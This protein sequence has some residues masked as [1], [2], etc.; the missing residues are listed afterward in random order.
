MNSQ[1]LN[2]PANKILVIGGST[3]NPCTPCKIRD[4]LATSNFLDEWAVIFANHQYWRLNDTRYS[5]DTYEF[6]IRSEFR[7]I[8]I[9]LIEQ[10]T[11]YP[12]N[13]NHLYILPDPFASDSLSATLK[14]KN[15][16]LE[17]EVSKEKEVAIEEI[18]KQDNENQL[19]IECRRDA[20]DQQRD[21]WPC[22]DKVMIEIANSSSQLSTIAGLIIC[23]RDGDGAYGL[24]EIQA[25]G[26]ATAVQMP[27][28]CIYSGADSMPRAALKL[29]SHQ[30]VSLEYPPRTLTLT[31]WLCDLKER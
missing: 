24:K 12:V 7:D 5:R 23:G 15:N 25:K 3:Y 1:S 9:I 17:I 31:Q 11:I 20:S 27:N 28:E 21:Y 19:P 26:G 10:I 30:E 8:N 16:L 22:I 29:H 2:K 14:I 18:L 13:Q 6:K 4:A